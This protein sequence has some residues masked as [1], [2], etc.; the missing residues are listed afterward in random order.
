M[1]SECSAAVDC[2]VLVRGSLVLAVLVFGCGGGGADRGCPETCGGR[3]VP[4][5]ADWL[6]RDPVSCECEPQCGRGYEW[7]DDRCVRIGGGD[8]DAGS[9]GGTGSCGRPCDDDRDCDQVCVDCISGS[10]SVIDES[11]KPCMDGDGDGHGSGYDCPGD[12]DDSDPS[13]TDSATRPCYTGPDGTEGVGVCVG[14]T[15][16][17]TDGAWDYGCVGDVVPTRETCDGSD[18]NC[19]GVVDDGCP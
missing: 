16:T 18:Q 17:C 8:A 9:D 15:E 19:N 6:V 10:C 5:C 4:A 7:R 13:I 11:G 2:G 3:C 1:P 12:C 14:G